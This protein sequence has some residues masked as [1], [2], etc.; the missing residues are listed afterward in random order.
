LTGLFD[1]NLDF[2][3][4]K[5]KSDEGPAIFEAVQRV[6]LKLEAQQGPVEVV[7]IDHVEKPSAN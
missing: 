2:N 4:D 1:L 3:V 6:G 5:S 7:V